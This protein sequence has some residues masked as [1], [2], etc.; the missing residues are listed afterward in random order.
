MLIET[1]T[2]EVGKLYAINYLSEKKELVEIEPSQTWFYTPE[3][4]AGELG[5]E[6]DRKNGVSGKVFDADDIEGILLFLNSPE[7]MNA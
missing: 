2:L 4:I 7:V 6:E 1:E 5:V 3:W